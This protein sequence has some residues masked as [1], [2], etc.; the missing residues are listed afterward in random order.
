MPEKDKI[1]VVDDDMTICTYLENFFS[2][3]SYQVITTQTGEDAIDIINNEKIDVILLDLVLPD[4]DGFRILD[5]IH[6]RD[7]DINVII[8]TG[9]ASL[10]SAVEAVRKG[11]YDY[12]R[13]PFVNEELLKTTSNA[14]DHKKLKEYNRRSEI[15]LLESEDRFANL[16]VNSLSGIAIIQKDNVVYQNPE[17]RKLFRNL[18]EPFSIKGFACVHP[19][20][21]EKVNQTY[22]SL[23]SERVKIVD[24]DFRFFPPGKTQP[25]RDMVWVQCRASHF[26]YKNQDAIL[27]N[28]MDISRAKE[29]EKLIIIKDKMASL[30]RVAAGIAHEIRNPLSGINSYLFSM[31]DICSM[32]KVEPEDIQQLKQI[33]SRI[34]MSSNKIEAVVKRVLDFSRPSTPKMIMID[35]N[36]TLIETIEL[37]MATLRKNEVTLEQDLEENLPQCYGDG[38][39]IEQVILNLINNAVNAMGYMTSEKKMRITSYKKHDCVN[40]S[41]ADSGPGVPVELREK[42]FDPFFTTETDGSGIGLSISQR[43]IADHD[44]SIRVDT[45]QWGGADFNVELPIE[46]RI[47]PR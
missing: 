40:I 2:R 21:F 39:L 44:G 42:I 13:K 4:M 41:V 47:N 6:Q 9:Y 35:I 1:L 25:H 29:L 46:K 12:L 14:L 17:Q 36:N 24:L 3:Y 38:H 7:P 45:S 26:V 43:I 16:I 19:D 10:E 11:A 30:G 33:T 23:I 27:V 37:T 5:F 8:I 22:Q 20:D 32:E 34:Q 28:M 18:Q 31:E 15:A